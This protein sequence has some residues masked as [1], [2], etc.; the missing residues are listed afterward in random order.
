V[1]AAASF[2]LRKFSQLQLHLDSSVKKLVGVVLSSRTSSDCGDLQIVKKLHRRSILLLH[3]RDGCGLL[4]PFGDFPSA[5]NN[6]R[7][8]LGGAVAAVRRRQS[9]EVE[10]EE[11]LKD[12]D[13]MLVFF[14]CSILFIISFNTK[15]L[16]K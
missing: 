14:K 9:L 1:V 2:S 13:V 12:F 8:A 6:V 7:S 4:G 11:H 15:V 5:T 16:L 3:L 10:D